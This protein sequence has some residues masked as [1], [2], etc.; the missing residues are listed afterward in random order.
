MTVAQE[1]DSHAGRAELLSCCWV[2]ILLIRDSHDALLNFFEHASVLSIISREEGNLHDDTF[3][4]SEL[5][6]TFGH[7]VAHVVE[8]Q[9]HVLSE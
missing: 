4:V 9:V 6:S 5:L 7:L 2:C 8:C 1:L 3:R